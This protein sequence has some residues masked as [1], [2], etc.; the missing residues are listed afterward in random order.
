M[1]ENASR[2]RGNSLSAHILPTSATMIGVCM[3]VLS[4]IHLSHG[5][6]LRWALDELLALDALAFLASAV[7]SFVSMR[8]E[9][10]AVALER[11]AETIFVAGL[12]LLAL[13]AVAIAF[14]I[15]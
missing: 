1:K 15:V 6:D 9:S 12:A 4:L 10:D 2:E 8:R 13:G 7:L 3:T 5:S 11:R 14:V